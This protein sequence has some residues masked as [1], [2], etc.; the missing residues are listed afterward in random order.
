MCVS[1]LLALSMSQAQA[2]NEEPGIHDS[3]KA[4]R[5]ALDQAGVKD[6]YVEYAGLAREWQTWRKQLNDFAPLLFQ[7]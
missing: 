1:L 6:T 4:T 3:L 7:R 2:P 5:T